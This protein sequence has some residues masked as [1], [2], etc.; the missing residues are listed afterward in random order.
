MLKLNY[1]ALKVV[2]VLLQIIL[3]VLL[4]TKNFFKLFL[5]FDFRFHL[6]A[7][8]HLYVLAVEKR[9]VIPRDV[10]TNKACYVELEIV[11]KVL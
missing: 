1:R 8:R 11:Y 7:F 5:K 3:Y 10:S 6:Q 2:A 9:L 4:S